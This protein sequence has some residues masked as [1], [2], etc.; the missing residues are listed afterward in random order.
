MVQ[1]A[2]AFLVGFR[3]KGKLA[4]FLAAL[5]LILF[6][7]MVRAGSQVRPEVFSITYILLTIFVFVE[8]IER[9]YRELVPLMWTA[10]WIFLA[11]QAKITNLFFLPG[12]LVA[13]LVYKKNLRHA[14]ILAGVL[15]FMYLAETSLY[16]IFTEYKMGMLEIITQ[17][18]FSSDDPFILDTFWGFFMRYA[19]SKL[20]VYWQIPFL[21]FLGAGLVTMIRGKD[22]SV[23]A[24][25]IAAFSFFFCITFE[26]KSFSPITPAEQ[27]INRYFS[28]VLGPVFIVLGCTV[29][30]ILAWLGGS[31]RH[32]SPSMSWK[33]YGLI[34]LIGLAVITAIPALPFVPVSV[35]QYVNDPFKPKRHPLALN[36]EYWQEINS[37]YEAGKPIIARDSNS[38]Q[39]AI[40][41]A[42][43]YYLDPEKFMHGSAPRIET[44]WLQGAAFMVL[45]NGSVDMSGLGYLAVVRAPFKAEMVH[46]ADLAELTGDSFAS[47][48]ELEAS[49][50]SDD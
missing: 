11:Y 28:A 36:V 19:P 13:I 37:T 4:G 2:L 9:E 22:R 12:F 40:H 34:L 17:K 14:L 46:S 38:G 7:Y 45:G 24:I 8:Y 21:L 31:F 39:N 30:D 23:G 25:A 10:V 32:R 47:S 3:L 48:R 26:A 20:Q 18:H 15:F 50:S 35:R 6:P 42:M 29:T 5:G 33:P 27:F 49:G 1:A 41:S 16:A 43:G 44:K